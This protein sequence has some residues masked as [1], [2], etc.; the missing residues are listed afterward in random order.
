MSKHRSLFCIEQESGF[1]LVELLTTCAILAVLSALS[2]SAFRVYS[3]EAEYTKA[4]ATLNYARK[5]I[6]VGEEDVPAGFN[7]AYV[8]SGVDGEPLEGVLAQMLPG[9]SASPSVKLSARWLD[10]NGQGPFAEHQLLVA[11]PCAGK[12]EVRWQSFCGGASV[13]L[14]NVGNDNPCD[15]GA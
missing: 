11:Q 6:V 12:K 5:A 13:L 10:C 1:T 3:R 9:A 7:S 15:K 2:V 4:E 14:Q 8:S